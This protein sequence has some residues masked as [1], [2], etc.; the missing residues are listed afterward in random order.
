MSLWGGLLFSPKKEGPSDTCYN[1]DDLEDLVL[2]EIY[3]T[4]EEKQC[5]DST[6]VIDSERRWV[7]RGRGW[8][9]KE[10]SVSRGNPSFNL[11]KM[12]VFWRWAVAMA[13]QD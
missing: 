1:R 4:Q 2:S 11:G 7:G 5:V 3:Q 12:D 10:E 13:A 9:R 8:W 6:G